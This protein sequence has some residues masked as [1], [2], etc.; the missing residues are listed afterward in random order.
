MVSSKIKDPSNILDYKE[1]ITKIY[2][3]RHGQTNANKN[4]L[5]FGRLDWDLNTD[6]IKEAK[7]I[8]IKLSEALKNIN[9]HCLISSPLNRAKHT[10]KIISKKLNI[11]NITIDKDLTEKSEGL[12]EGKTFWQVR[13]E[14][15]AN[16]LRWI[17]NPLRNKPPKGE[18]T[19][20][21]NLRVQ[22]FY[23]LILKKYTG[24]NIIVVAHSGPIKL[25]LLKILGLPIE[26][27]WN[28][29]V[30]CGSYSEIHLSKRHCIAARL[31]N[32]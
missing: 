20:D 13:N 30:D 3:V 21:L 8:S 19:Y 26:K 25:F 27:F 5:L 22:K 17:T 4:G 12:W 28:I 29:K 18:S 14:D 32:L 7:N 31:N 2:L 24:K 15:H 11:K 16:F 10:A 9:I 23:K 1:P 6:G